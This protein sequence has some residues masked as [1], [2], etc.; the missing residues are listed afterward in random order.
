VLRGLTLVAV[1]LVLAW[2]GC[3]QNTG[4]RLAISGRVTFRGAPLEKG[5]IEFISADGR[6]QSGGTVATGI[7]SVPAAKGLPPGKYTVRIS[8]VQESGPAPTGPPGP[9][10]MS[11]PAQDLIPPEYN[12]QSRLTAEVTAGGRNHFEFDLK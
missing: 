3:G 10:S 12:V 2:A 7:Y 9:E 8:A 6:H 1:T 4:G 11:Q 5:V